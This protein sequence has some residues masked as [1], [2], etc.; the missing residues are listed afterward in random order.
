MSRM[1]VKSEREFDRGRERK[2]I[3]D[4]VFVFPIDFSE[5]WR[6]KSISKS[7]TRLFVLFLFGQDQ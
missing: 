2:E 4:T 1:M 3:Q 5:A 7:S 6:Q